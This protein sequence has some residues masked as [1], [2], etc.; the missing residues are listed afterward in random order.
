MFFTNQKTKYCCLVFIFLLFG[1]L[2]YQQLKP[3]VIIKPLNG[4]IVPK[5][6]QK[7]TV[8]NWFDGTY[9]KTVEEYFNEKFGFRNI[10]VRLNNQLLFSLFEKTTAKG[11][12]IGK[13]G[14]LYEKDYIDAYYGRNFIGADSIAETARKLKV[15]QDTLE[16]LNKT[17]L[18]IL[19]P[20][21]ASFFPEFIPDALKG[22]KT[23]TNNEAYVQQFKTRGLN[24]IDLNSYFPALKKTTEYP[25]YPKNGIHWSCY[26]A[27][28]AFDSI[29]K[30]FEKKLDLD[31]IDIKV[32]KTEL[33]DT[34]RY[35]DN[36]II[37]GMNLMVDSK[38][39][40]L[41]YISKSTEIN[42]KKK[43]P[44]LLVVSDSYWWNITT[45]AFG[46][47][48]FSDERFWFCYR[49][50]YPESY[51]SFTP[52]G[53]LKFDE[54]IAKQDV[55]IIMATEATTNRLGYDFVDHL[56]KY[57]KR[58]GKPKYDQ[59][60]L[61]GWISHIRSNENWMKGLKARSE[62]EK[63][64]LDSLVKSDAIWYLNNQN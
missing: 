22:N 6:Y 43:M 42:E 37:L 44:K 25:L 62:K 56:Y 59:A 55:I 9:Q 60:K 10:F 48:V 34:A 17:L 54:I 36:D 5:V 50:A 28:V 4:A 32:T 20:G 49:E 27:F 15:I 58:S 1:V 19:A 51:S 16:R 14:Y 47:Y 61:D 23:I 24:H 12:V 26:G 38:D 29:Y 52:V 41:A 46:K 30:W 18:V 13:E 53:S 45:Y 2:L 64:P 35:P 39:M 33:S 8:E 3:F 21:K 40:P 57:C 63:I 31:L 7:L 11:V